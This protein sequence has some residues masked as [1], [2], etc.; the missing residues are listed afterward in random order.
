MK[1][2]ITLIIII[3]VIF[4][5]FSG[6]TQS[7]ETAG[8][9]NIEEKNYRTVTDSRGTEAKVPVDIERV[10]TVSDGL[11]E[12]V[13]YILGVNDKIVALGSKGLL[14]TSEK[15]YVYPVDDGTNVTTP[16]GNN[17]ATVLSPRIGDLPTFIDYGVA[18]NYETLAAA[19]PDI[20]IIRLGSSA[21]LSC[22]DENA[23]KSIE[24]IES[25]GIPVVVLYSPNCYENS[26][27]T[28]I[29][30]EIKIIG[31]V[32]GEEEKA[33]E[34][35]AELESMKE[36]IRERTAQ[37]SEDEKKDVLVLGLSSMHRTETAAGIAWGLGT[38][39]SYMIEDLLNAR[40]AFRSDTGSFQVVSTEQVLSMEPDV[41]LLGTASGYHPPGELYNATY[42]KNLRELTAVKNHRVASL[43]YSPRNAA[44]RLEYPVDLMVTAK[45]VYPDLFEDIDLGEWILEFYQKIYGVDRDTATELR[46]AQLMDWCVEEE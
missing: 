11:V 37:V 30:D 44:K 34:I 19:D 36:S 42:Y 3:F 33:E 6:C 4:T 35:G 45:T 12:E 40:N 14:F 46:T 31:Q 18:M 41:I 13:M 24:R 38:T 28:A 9:Q 43:P 39:E 27:P 7:G 15:N 17:V 5:A 32:F 10:A 8:A 26:D 20:V 23:K 25:L 22:E 21:F 1:P 29:S 16:A 2:V